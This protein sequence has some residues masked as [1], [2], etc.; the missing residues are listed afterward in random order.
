MTYRGPVRFPVLAPALTLLLAAPLVAG[1][2]ASA[3][4]PVVASAAKAQPQARQITYTE[5]DTG[6]DWR[7]G[8]MA[9]TRVIK[10]D[11]RI[12]APQGRRVY[13]GRRYDRAHWVSPWVRGSHDFTRLIASWNAHTPGDSLIEVRVRGRTSSGATSSWDVLARWTAS[14]RF[15]QRRTAGTQPDDLA[16]VNVDTWQTAGLRDHQLRVTLMR[17][18]GKRY[19]PSLDAVGAVVS[20]LPASAGATSK[21]GPARGKVLPVPRYSQ[22]VHSGHYPR[23][24]NG[25]QAWCSPTATSMVLGYYGALPKR[26]ERSWVPKGHPQPFVDHA[27]RMTYDYAY[28]GAG[29]WPFNT[30]YAAPRVGHGFVTRLRSLREAERLIVAGIPVVASI[31]FGRGELRGA[32]ISRTNGHL[33]VIVGFTKAGDVVVNDPAAPNNRTVRRTYDRGQL[34]RAWLNASG[35]TV[36][37]IHDDAHPLPGSPTN[38]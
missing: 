21:P 2:P 22:M 19:T 8:E 37:V 27:A 5:F 9:G 25:G 10:G 29:N 20:R 36:Y 38:W 17:Q 7:S 33:V 11:L 15:T 12:K 24:G 3:A 23:W 34:E 14:D 32:P 6:R 16:S 13:R 4:G 30:A 1:P 18:T 35:G 26:K 28:D 31:A